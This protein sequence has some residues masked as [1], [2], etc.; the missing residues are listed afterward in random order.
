[1][2]I[3]ACLPV[4]LFFDI[5]AG[6]TGF[7]MTMSATFNEASGSLRTIF[8]AAGGFRVFAKVADI[9]GKGLATARTGMQLPYVA[10]HCSNNYL[11]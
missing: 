3:S 5:P 10:V 8:G 7:D 9:L 4:L 11:P 1:V 6:R 2:C